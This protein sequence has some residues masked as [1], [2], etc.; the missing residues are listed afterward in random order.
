MAQG[1]LSRARRSANGVRRLATTVQA[2]RNQPDW[3]VAS[4]WCVAC[5]GVGMIFTGGWG[6]TDLRT[7]TI[8]ST[9]SA[10]SDHSLMTLPGRDDIE[11]VAIEAVHVGDYVFL[12][13]SAPPASARCVINKRA[14]ANERTARIVGWLVELAGGQLAWWTHDAPVWRRRIEDHA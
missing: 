14:K 9:P 10:A 7:D 3:R 11:R 8:G 12:E 13:P 5:F 2:L 1:R 6:M 4:S